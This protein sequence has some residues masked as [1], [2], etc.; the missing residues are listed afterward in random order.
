MPAR[1]VVTVEPAT[2]GCCNRRAAVDGGAV[3]LFRQTIH[4][5]QPGGGGFMLIRLADG[6]P[7]DFVNAR[8]LGPRPIYS[9]QSG[10]A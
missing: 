1:M 4:R 8:P 6:A 3:G 5:G 2:E 10:Q 9:G 7:L